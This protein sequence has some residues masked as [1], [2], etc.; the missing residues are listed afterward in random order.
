[1]TKLN[2]FPSIYFKH[3]E[4]LHSSYKFFLAIKK[5]DNWDFK[6]FPKGGHLKLAEF[7]LHQRCPLIGENNVQR[8]QTTWC[9]LT[10]AIL[11]E[12]P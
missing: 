2:G 6:N 4:T 9:L 1:M 10:K 5:I 8:F 3:L 11:N 7:F 12:L